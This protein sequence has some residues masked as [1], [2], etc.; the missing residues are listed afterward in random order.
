MEQA[1]GSRLG[2]KSSLPSPQGITITD[3]VIIHPQSMI[4]LPAA[5]VTRGAAAARKD[6][7]KRAVFL[8]VELNGYTCVLFSMESYDQPLMALL[9]RLGDEAAGPGGIS[10]ASFVAG[11]L[12]EIG[13]GLCRGNLILYCG[14]VGMLD[15]A[16]GSHFCAWLHVPTDNIV[17]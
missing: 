9:Y 12:R 3:V 2:R 5:V 10:R 13:I 11:T 14:I 6:Q 15:R 17:A 16:T 8:R 4:T 1:S 7:Q